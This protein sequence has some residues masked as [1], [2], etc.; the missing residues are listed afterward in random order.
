MD[1]SL[2]LR[3]A[4]MAAEENGTKVYAVT[5]STR[6]QPWKDMEIA[7]KVAQECGCE[8]HVLAIDESKNEKILN[9]VDRC[10]WCKRFLFE[11]LFKVGQ[12]ARGSRYTG[13]APSDDL[14]MYRPGWKAVKRAG[15]RAPLAELGVTKEGGAP[16]GCPVKPF[17]GKEA[18]HTLHGNKNSL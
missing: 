5:I 12:P 11:S 8:H 9:T 18:L 15:V 4:S 1:S 10:Y 3:T 13:G 16:D 17:C 14:D 6:L 2:L 7:R